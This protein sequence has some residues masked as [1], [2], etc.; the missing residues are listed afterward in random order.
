[1]AQAKEKT[2]YALL[3]RAFFS[4]VYSEA[5]K[6]VWPNR[7]TMIQ[8]TMVVLVVIL[9]LSIYMALMYFVWGKLFDLIT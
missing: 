7:D 2:N 4:E 6:I 3:I 9:A 5:K 8:S 1:M